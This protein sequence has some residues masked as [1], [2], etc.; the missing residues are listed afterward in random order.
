VE[1][2]GFHGRRKSMLEDIAGSRYLMTAYATSSD[3]WENFRL[4][5][6]KASL[7]EVAAILCGAWTALS[8]DDDFLAGLNEM[9][10][11][12]MAD[13]LKSALL[14]DF[15]PPEDPE[16][17]KLLEDVAANR[18]TDKLLS[19]EMVILVQAGMDPVHAVRLV[20]DLSDLI[21]RDIQPIET[22]RMAALRARVPDLASELCK[23]ERVLRAFDYEAAAELE[24]QRPPHRRWIRSLRIVGSGL[25]ATAGAAAAVGNVVAAVASFGVVTGFGL[26]SVLGGAE[27]LATAVEDVLGGER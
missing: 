1:H 22:T 8:E 16:R 3:S 6:D 14:G 23:A 9:T 4:T 13:D 21:R 25:K 20:T 2:S 15:A 7:F 26:C 17:R 12:A 19:Q 10:E 5:G 18:Q 24:A 27:A 11:D